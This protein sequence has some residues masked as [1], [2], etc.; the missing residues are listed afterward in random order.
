ME[1]PF[2]AL[3]LPDL[4][5]VEAEQPNQVEQ[6][7]QASVGQQQQNQVPIQPLDIPMEE[8]IQ[9][10]DVPMEDPNQPNQPNQLQNILPDPMAN[11]QQ[12][13]KCPKGKEILSHP[14]WQS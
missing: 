2:H 13:P 5:P 9:P 3:E 7:N 4:P 12:L 1:F 11:P 8:P 6:P 14:Y 10:L